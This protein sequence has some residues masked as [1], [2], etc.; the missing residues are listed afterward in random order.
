MDKKEYRVIYSVEDDHW[1]YVGLRRL[2]LAFINN[3][4]RGKDNQVILDAGCG[5]GGML[6]ECNG[7]NAFGLDISEEAMNFCR[8]RKLPNVS[9]GSICDIPFEDNS[10]NVIISLDVLYHLDVSDDVLALKEF[11]RVTAPSGMLILNLPAYDFLRSSH[12]K[13]NYT[14]HRYTLREVRDKVER[15]GFA[16]ERITY[17]NT[18]LFPLAAAVRTI[19]KMF[20]GRGDETESDLKP[21]PAALNKFLKCVLDLENRLILSGLNFPFGLSLF[22]VARKR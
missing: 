2:V 17:R 5:T 14:R 9:L 8:I 21:V 11:Y 16:I 13:M 10:F 20:P 12:D 18:A 19:K 3:F 4:V 15:A 6:A 1:W 7:Y 22:C